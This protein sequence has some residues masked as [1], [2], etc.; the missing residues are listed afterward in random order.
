MKLFSR[1]K[2]K[3]I[4]MIGERYSWT[5]QVFKEILDSKE[6]ITITAPACSGRSTLA[7]DILI[8]KYKSGFCDET[9]DM[10]YYSPVSNPSLDDYFAEVS[11]NKDI[12][13]YAD[14]KMNTVM[15]PAS[16]QSLNNVLSSGLKF[17]LIVVD[18]V[19]SMSN[20]AIENILLKATI[21]DARLIVIGKNVDNSLNSENLTKRV[22]V[23]LQNHPSYISYN[24][25]EPDKVKQ[26]VGLTTTGRKTM[27]DTI[28]SVKS[29]LHHY[30][31]Y[32]GN[33]IC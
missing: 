33:L 16:K 4:Y 9:K 28:K 3:N 14:E 2:V 8:A 21:D 23:W 17:S 7:A 19:E 11:K 26:E 25:I 32:G 13:I 29:M 30:N 15:M 12:H 31:I 20:T 22:W 5:N 1:Y 18:D 24:I 27:S 6:N 10:L